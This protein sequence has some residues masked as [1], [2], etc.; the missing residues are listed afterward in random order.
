MF[1]RGN[2]PRIRSSHPLPRERVSEFAAPEVGRPGPG[3]E[4]DYRIISIPPMLAL[5]VTVVKFTMICPEAFA[6]AVNSRTTAL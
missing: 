3:T 1:P 2:S 6:V 4:C 5:S